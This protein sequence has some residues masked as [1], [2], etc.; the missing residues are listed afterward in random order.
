LTDTPET[1]TESPERASARG[2]NRRSL[3]AA[4]R[5]A[6]PTAAYSTVENWVRRLAI[7]TP[8]GYFD[9]D[10]TLTAIASQDPRGNR[11]PPRFSEVDAPVTDD[12]SPLPAEDDVDI[13]E[14]RRR[15]EC[16]LARKLRLDND[17]VEGELIVATE[18]LLV[19]R[20]AIRELR[21]RVLMV[22]DRL[23]AQLAAEPDIGKCRA[24]VDTALREALVA[25]R[26]EAP[27]VGR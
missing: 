16:Q 13:D 22:P 19:W 20:T 26:D 2:L 10:R 6:Y 23:A 27:E 7:K 1:T 25:A 15:K 8:T 17:Q 18:A 4:L 12:D 5:E 3:I 11:R 14:A 9:L 24:L 21:D